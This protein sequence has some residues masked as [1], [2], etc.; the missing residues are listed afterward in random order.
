MPKP[1]TVY[2]CNYRQPD[3]K[4]CPTIVKGYGARCK[5]HK[6]LW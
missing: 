6:Y 5:K 1:H 3:G 2:H 4:P